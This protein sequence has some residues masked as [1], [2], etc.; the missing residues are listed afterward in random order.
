MASANAAFERSISELGM[1]V[2]LV[3][4]QLSKPEYKV[5]SKRA[6]VQYGLWGAKS[7]NCLTPFTA[8]L[9]VRK[10]SLYLGGGD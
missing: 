1:A 9:E 6:R 4:Q 7:P 3:K 2:P 10:N 5:L 8:R